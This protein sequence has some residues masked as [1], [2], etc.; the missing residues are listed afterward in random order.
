M[1]WTVHNKI[2]QYS[3]ITKTQVYMELAFVKSRNSPLK[4]AEYVKL[5][6][7]EK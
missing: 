4:N 1:Y 7:V 3:V 5:K 2:D 6:L